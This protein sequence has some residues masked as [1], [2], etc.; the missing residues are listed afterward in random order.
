MMENKFCMSWYG[1]SDV[2]CHQVHV[3]YTHGTQV[4]LHLRDFHLMF[5]YY[6]EFVSW[7]FAFVAGFSNAFA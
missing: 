7:R 1:K 2:Y 5:S 4:Q 6:A 3:S